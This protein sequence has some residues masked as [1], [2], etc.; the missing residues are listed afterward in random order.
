MFVLRVQVFG[1]LSIFPSSV[2]PCRLLVQISSMSPAALGLVV[3]MV[4]LLWN[5]SAA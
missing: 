3:K 2:V 5:T 1:P 4:T